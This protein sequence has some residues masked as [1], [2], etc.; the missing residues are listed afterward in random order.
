MISSVRGRVTAVGPNEAVV[1]IGGAAGGL[2]FSV[3][4]APATLATLQVGAETTLH[5]SLV[6]REDSLT[7]YGF[8]APAERGLFELLQTAS[9]VGPKLAQAIIAVLD[10]LTVRRALASGDIATLTRVPGVGKKS[11]ERMILELRERIGPVPSA[12]PAPAT[13]A[14]P[15]AAWQDQVT[16]GLVGLGWSSRDAAAAIA[17]VAESLPEGEPVPAMPVLLRQAIRQ[18]GRTK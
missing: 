4:C 6:V 8:A 14:G 9:G 16:Q 1:D 15:A 3:Q 18:L 7:L 10:P 17:A 2:G 12:D 13:L 11:A 5:T